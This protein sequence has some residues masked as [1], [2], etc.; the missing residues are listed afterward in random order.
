MPS[1]FL[2]VIRPFVAMIPNIGKPNR[3]VFYNEKVLW[4][5]LALI[6][7][8]LMSSIPIIG[9][10]R[11]KGDPFALI[12]T[13]TAS[14]HGSL[15]EVGVGAIV[16]ASLIMHV[17]VGLK[18]VKVNLEDPK[19][20]SLYH[21]SEKFI[22]LVITIVV[23]IILVIGGTY[24]TNLNP[25]SQLAIIAQ[26]YCTGVIIIYLDEILRKGWGF[27]P[28]IFLF[29]AGGVGLQIFQGLF[30][31]QPF[32]EGPEP[33]VT[34]MRGIALA[35]LA[36]ATRRGPIEAAGA[37][38][39]RYSPAE[40]V[41]L[42]SLSLLSVIATIVVFFIV[43]YLESIH[44]EIP[45]KQHRE[46]RLKYPI[47][48]FSLSI[49]PLILA[50]TVLANFYFIAFTVWNAS[51][52]TSTTY[53]LTLFLGTFRVDPTS[54][55]FVPNSGLVYYMTPPQSLVGDF[56]VITLHDPLGSFVRTLIYAAI[57]I[58]LT[59]FFSIMNLKTTGIGAH[60]IMKQSLFSEIRK[61]NQD[62]DEKSLEAR[63]NIYFHKITVILGFLIG[64]LA[65]LADFFGVLGTGVGILLLISIIR[66]YSEDTEVMGVS[67][68]IFGE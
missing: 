60:E 49:I 24:G 65:V 5:L 51:G 32:L 38:F 35:F 31:A 14:T 63:F 1:R 23:P 29:I 18:I 68:Y 43:I 52:G 58:V 55:K 11:E 26:L 17:L 44:L 28:G 39:F 36:W 9:A 27:G 61:L 10:G 3:E 7:Y 46:I 22:A 54:H 21:G 2:Q 45:L 12:R 37:L 6:I 16:T 34:S 47:K 67:F 41:N 4:T 40:N 20:K 64:L 15:A 62:S 56:G 59:M 19:E 30:A 50:S 57:F 25:F 53:P 13:V 48:L 33:G 42:P 8:F 66:Q